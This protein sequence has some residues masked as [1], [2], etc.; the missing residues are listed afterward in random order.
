MYPTQATGSIC[1]KTVE[2][3]IKSNAQ[4]ALSAK[5]NSPIEQKISDLFEVIRAA[6]VGADLLRE[7]LLPITAHSP[8]EEAVS[9]NPQEPTALE[10]QLSDA[11]LQVSFLSTE[12][13]ILRGELRI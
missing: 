8:R 10:Q 11:I 5:E 9:V 12:L 1:T 7:K 6:R 2:S 13:S 3:V 4:A